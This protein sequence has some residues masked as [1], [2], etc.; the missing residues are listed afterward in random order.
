MKAHLRGHVP[1]RNNL[2]SRQFK[3]S[4]ANAR[5]AARYFI[6]TGSFEDLTWKV[7]VDSASNS[8]LLSI[9]EAAL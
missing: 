3:R 4:D 2:Q 6:R 9:D 7:E 5:E 8:G 1:K